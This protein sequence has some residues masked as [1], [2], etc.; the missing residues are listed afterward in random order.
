METQVRAQPDM[1]AL[2]QALR[3]GDRE[4]AI[5]LL[6]AQLDALYRFVARQIR[7]HIALGQIQP[8][9]LDPIEVVNE[10]M[11]EALRRG[12]SSPRRASLRGWLRL[13]ALRA[14]QRQMRRLQRQRR[15]ESI[16]LEQPLRPGQEWDAYYQPDAALTWADVLPAPDPSPEQAILERE[17]IE[18]LERALDRLPANQRLIFILRAIEGLSYAEIS[19]MLHQPRDRI[20]QIYHAAREALSRQLADQR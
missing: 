9:D 20:R 10:I 3:A 1:H 15:H 8:G 13:L 12:Q 18:E 19:A 14:L 6:M 2:H 11:L 16:S 4:Q 17:T 7:Y 5:E